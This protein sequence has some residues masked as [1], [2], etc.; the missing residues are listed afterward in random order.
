MLMER[1]QLPIFYEHLFHGKLPIGYVENKIPV[2][3]AFGMTD[4]LTHYTQSIAR[5]LRQDNLNVYHG[6][7]IQILKR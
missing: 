1:E 6:A 2:Y 5:S 4:P 7:S 3:N